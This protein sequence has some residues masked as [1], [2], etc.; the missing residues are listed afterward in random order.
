MGRLKLSK[1]T[2]EITLRATQPVERMEFSSLELTEPGLANQ[3][4]Q[5]A[6]EMHNDRRDKHHQCHRDNAGNAE[7]S[8]AHSAG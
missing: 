2:H 3:L 1:G 8:D 6:K 7:G 5:Q 4:G